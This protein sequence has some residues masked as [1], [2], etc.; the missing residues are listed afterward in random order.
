MQAIEE[1]RSRRFEHAASVAA[2]AITLPA[3]VFAA[4]ALPVQGITS[5]GHDL[6]GW[7]VVAIGAG[8]ML[9]GAIAGAI[10]GRWISRRAP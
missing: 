9:A 1:K 4:L 5:E 8:T 6:P 3:L 7:L 2:I 10:G